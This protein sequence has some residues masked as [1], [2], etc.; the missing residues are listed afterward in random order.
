M[1]E[2]VAKI[3]AE[4]ARTG[5]TTPTA[6]QEATA[7]SLLS[8]GQ[9]T[10]DMLAAKD[11]LRNKTSTTGMSSEAL[12]AAR[13]SQKA[14]TIIPLQLEAAMSAMKGARQSAAMERDSKVLGEQLAKTTAIKDINVENKTAE[15][16]TLQTNMQLLNTFNETLALKDKGLSLDIEK[17][18]TDNDIA[19]VNK[20]IKEIE[21]G[22]QAKTKEGLDQIALL[23]DKIE[24]RRNKS[25]SDRGTIEEKY[26]SDK[27]AGL[28]AI[29]KIEEDIT[30]RN[31]ASADEKQQADFTNLETQ[32]SMNTALGLLTTQQAAAERARI[33]LLKEKIDFDAK[34]YAI[35]KEIAAL[36]KDQDK[37][38]QAKAAEPNVDFTNEQD[39]LDRQK[40][41]IE[42]T[43]SSLIASNEARKG[44]IRNT[45]EMSSQMVGFSKIV[46]GAFQGM[47]DA[48][49]TFVQ[50]GKLDFKGLVDSMIADLIRFELRAQM[51]ALYS[52]LGGLS[53]ILG[54]LFGGT[55]VVDSTATMAATTA[56]A[57]KGR[58]YDYGIQKFAMGGAFTN[59][60]V[61]SPTLFKYAQG[62]GLMGEAGPEAIM[63]LKRDASGNLGVRSG[64]QQPNV[65]VVVNNYST[66]QATTHET[67]DSRGNRRIEV[68]IGD[69]TAGEIS[70]SG[71][72][73]QRSI[74]NTFG[75]Q[76][77]LIRR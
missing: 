72:S 51:S 12:T 20:Q 68:T 9:S 25:I 21:Q 62:T 6:Q 29:R 71:S 56:F 13:Q 42:N 59:Q 8:S 32:L 66:A 7:N 24:A 49:T 40:Q 19:T 75:L 76:P 48:L 39:R 67:T 45:Q 15:Q 54:K 5:R 64:Q 38:N 65:D 74:R 34:Y 60:V 53:G 23:Q 31:K 46:E 10:L 77:Q 69:M 55:P 11:A 17:L 47:A 57:A 73:S 50:T 16:K 36:K 35:E 1:L 26:K 33:D 4:D 58:A 44:V 70:R 30:T 2:E 3:R 27:I 14:D 22:T 63:P 18:N 41:S 61:N 43:K 52:S 37:L 28:E